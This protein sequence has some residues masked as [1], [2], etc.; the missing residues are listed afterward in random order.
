ML[1]TFHTRAHA[2]I[3]LFGNIAKALLVMMGHSGTIPGAIL[4]TELP[5][6][7]ARLEGALAASQASE[8]VA[9]PL[10]DDPQPALALRALPLI[11]LLKAAIAADADVMWDS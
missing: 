6:A 10:S 3:T 4:S 7:L 1:V 11:G 5:A 2:D 8:S 9:D